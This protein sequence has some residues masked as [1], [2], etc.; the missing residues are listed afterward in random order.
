MKLK[1]AIN[2][3]K[4][5]MIHT[6]FLNEKEYLK[7]YFLTKIENNDYPILLKKNQRKEN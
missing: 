1:T 3:L 7:Q 6:C 4:I 2:L 5:K